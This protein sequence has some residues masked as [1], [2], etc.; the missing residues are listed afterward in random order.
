MQAVLKHIA[1]QPTFSLVPLLSLQ[2][3][4]LSDQVLFRLLAESQLHKCTQ[5]HAAIIIF[6]GYIQCAF[7][8]GI[9]PLTAKLAKGISDLGVCLWPPAWLSIRNNVKQNITNITWHDEHEGQD[10]SSYAYH[11]SMLSQHISNTFSCL[12]L[13][14]N[15]CCHLGTS[16]AYV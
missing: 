7:Q 13:W 10:I 16:S 12:V 9:S 5:L 4:I 1:S 14:S 6:T 2:D 11:H 15:W 3:L 8:T